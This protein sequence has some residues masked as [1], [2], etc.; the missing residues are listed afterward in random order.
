MIIFGA[1]VFVIAVAII[2]SSYSRLL[3]LIFLVFTI[4]FH[5]LYI[6]NIFKFKTNDVAKHCSKLATEPLRLCS[7]FDGI[8]EH[9]LLNLFFWRSSFEETLLYFALLDNFF[10]SVN[11]FYLELLCCWV[12]CIFAY[13]LITHWLIWLIKLID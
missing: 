4:L 8:C 1:I 13:N 11:N 9:Y 12:I 10:Y 2:I 6:S 3:T 5:L 7:V